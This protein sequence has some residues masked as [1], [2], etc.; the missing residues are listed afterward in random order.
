MYRPLLPTQVSN[1][2]RQGRQTRELECPLLLRWVKAP[3][4]QMMSSRSKGGAPPIISTSRE[5]NLGEVQPRVAMKL[6]E[7]VNLPSLR[8]Q[9]VRLINQR[10]GTVVPQELQIAENCNNVH[11]NV[12]TDAEG[13]TPSTWA[14]VPGDGNAPLAQGSA[15]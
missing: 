7:P 9:G 8:I 15:D 13:N 4:N 2:Y 5:K 10:S 14:T 3:L 11:E 1:D 6:G 12:S